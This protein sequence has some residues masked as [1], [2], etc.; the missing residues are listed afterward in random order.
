MAVPECPTSQ[1]DNQVDTVEEEPAAYAKEA[2]EE[3]ESSPMEEEFMPRQPAM[4]EPMADCSL[5]GEHTV[6]LVV[7]C[8]AL[9]NSTMKMT[10]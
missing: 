8:P 1:V 7:E 3:L 2:I 4:E 5:A 6:M 9:G 10:R